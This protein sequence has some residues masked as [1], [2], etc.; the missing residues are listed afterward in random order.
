MIRRTGPGTGHG[1][2]ETGSRK[3]ESSGPGS[4]SACPAV[5]GFRSPVP[6]CLSPVPGGAA[7]ARGL[8]LALAV[9]GAACAAPKAKIP[10]EL[11]ERLPAEGRAVIYDRENDLVIAQNRRDDARRGIERIDEEIDEHAARVERS[12]KRLAKMGFSARV[13]ALKQMAE[14]QRGYLEAQLEIARATLALAE[15]EIEAAGARLEQARQRQLVRF[16]LA[17]E[18]R[19]ASFDAAAESLDKR[20]RE[21][22]R[23]EADLRAAAQKVFENWKLAEDAY[24]RSTGDH[25]A[26]VWLD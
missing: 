12:E 24:A 5:S 6:R 10:P 23:K 22:E 19:M 4:G 7:R 25:D 2:P 9:L 21:A 1:K 16:G 20:V 14:A 13:A 17:P 8:A 3:P 11:L 18:A 26:L 15:A